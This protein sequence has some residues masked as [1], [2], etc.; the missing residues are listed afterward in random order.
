MRNI[1]NYVAIMNS[2]LLTHLK[3][4]SN[5]IDDQLQVIK[6]LRKSIL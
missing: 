5:N 2:D 1:L 3:K 6:L 4:N